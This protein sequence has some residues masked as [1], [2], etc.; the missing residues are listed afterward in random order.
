MFIKVG[1]LIKCLKYLECL[2]FIEYLECRK[3]IKQ[4]VNGIRKYVSLHLHI[5][6]L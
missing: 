4:K 2:K 1:K 3:F 6:I 5:C